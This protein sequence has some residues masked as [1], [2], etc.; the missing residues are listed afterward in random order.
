MHPPQPV[1][2]AGCMRWLHVLENV[3]L[4]V[5]LNLRIPRFATIVD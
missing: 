2:V 1:Q 3:W 5:D 4:A